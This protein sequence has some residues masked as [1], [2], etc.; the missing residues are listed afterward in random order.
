MAYVLD[1]DEE[2]RR[3][4]EEQGQA[5]SSSAPGLMGGAQ[6]QGNA[7]ASNGTT[8]GKP[9]GSGFVNLQKYLGVNKDS[10]NRMAGQ[11]LEQGKEEEGKLSTAQDS[12]R[13]IQTGYGVDDYSKDR[14]NF[15]EKDL[16]KPWTQIEDSSK[17]FLKGQNAKG[18]TG[19]TVDVVKNREDSLI[20][21]KDTLAE[22]NKLF[23]D[24]P[25]GASQR[26]NYLKSQFN[27]DGRYTAGEGAFDSFLT[28]A[29][30]KAQA[31]EFTN[32]AKSIDGKVSEAGTLAS[33]AQGIKDTI[34]ANRGEVD[35]YNTKFQALRGLL[36]QRQQEYQ[37]YLAAQ[38]AA[39]AERKAREA[40]GKDLVNTTGQVVDGV[41]GATTTGYIP[42]DGTNGVA[43]AV[44]DIG[45]GAS[46]AGKNV[47]D[48][49][50]GKKKYW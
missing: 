25:E 3:S 43:G 7:Q 48:T 9:T 32:R 2:N 50:T 36:G 16:E 5:A 29:S 10:A 46:D 14:L 13:G 21:A 24:G 31:G 49:I 11:V 35:A 45:G 42:V 47:T 33:T 6:A 26:A 39:E 15:T 22:K 18:Y 38:V 44:E 41:V 27:K 12:F 4:Q 40:A 37:D 28:G 20:N 30:D 23:A 34:K 19:H 17:N 1:Q 8:D